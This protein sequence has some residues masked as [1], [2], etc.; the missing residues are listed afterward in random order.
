MSKWHEYL[1]WRITL[2]GSNFR[3]DNNS[4]TMKMVRVQIAETSTRRLGSFRSV[5]VQSIP[6]NCLQSPTTMP[7]VKKALIQTDCGEGE[8]KHCQSMVAHASYS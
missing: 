1:S 4:K 3:G 6:V 7:S 8:V 5:V 2:K